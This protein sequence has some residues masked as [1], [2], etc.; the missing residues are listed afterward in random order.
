[1]SLLLKRT[2]LLIRLLRAVILRR[3]YKLTVLLVDGCNLKCQTCGI[4]KNKRKYFEP[5]DFKNAVKT[6]PH[7][8]VWLNLSG[9]EVTLHPKWPEL[10]E[11]ALSLKKGIILTITSNG[12]VPMPQ[13]LAECLIQNDRHFVYYYISIDG[14]GAQNDIA[15]GKPGAYSRATSMLKTLNDLA[16]KNPYIKVG[17]N[18]TVSGFN[19]P[20]FERDLEQIAEHSERVNITVV[21]NN[22][23]F[24]NESTLGDLVL[25]NSDVRNVYLHYLG[26][27]SMRH[28]ET[29][30]HVLYFH[31]F[32]QAATHHGRHIRCNSIKST[33]LL[34][35]DKKIRTCIPRF[36]NLGQWAGNDLSRSWYGLES[37]REQQASVIRNLNCEAHCR[38]NCERYTHLISQSLSPRNWFR[39]P[40]AYLKFAL[41]RGSSWNLNK[42]EK[43]AIQ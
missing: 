8:L 41:F 18:Y 42:L 21:Q 32:G 24:Q 17:I 43:S 20:T 3:P 11:F 5:E 36:E 6:F 40:V 37:V 27:K 1:M 4:W 13:E 12:S 33:I 22:K 34:S 23:Y 7:D 15:R 38:I 28:A 26:K 16:Y 9:G 31:F 19:R 29:I 35:V 25:P 30:F 39:Y 14:V 10:L 2:A